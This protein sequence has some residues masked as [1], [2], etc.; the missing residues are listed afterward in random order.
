MGEIRAQVCQAACGCSTGLTQGYKSAF[1][2]RE[3][4][5][6]AKTK[7]D[8]SAFLKVTSNFMGGHEGCAYCKSFGNVFL[9]SL[10]DLKFFLSPLTDWW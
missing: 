3:K 2:G 8:L 4:E 6:F 1:P 10:D 9:V 5:G 7:L